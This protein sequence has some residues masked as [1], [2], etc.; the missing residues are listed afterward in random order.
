MRRAVDTIGA[1]IAAAMDRNKGGDVVS[2]DNASL[3]ASRK[4][5]P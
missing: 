4:R 5:R 2:I 1:T 3:Q